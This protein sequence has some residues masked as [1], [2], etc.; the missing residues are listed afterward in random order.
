MGRSLHEATFAVVDVET[1]GIDPA[2]DRVVEVACV[3]TRGGRIIQTFSTLVHPERPIPASASAVHHITDT[4]VADAPRLANVAPSIAAMCADAIV[5]A[6]NA[7]FDLSFLP[8]LNHR[9]VLCSMRLAQRVV[10]DAPNHKNQVLRYHLGIDLSGLTDV[11]AHRALGDAEITSR[12]LAI[13]LERYLSQGGA[14][15]ASLLV[16]ELAAPR[17]L[18]ALPFG[19]HRGV[20][21]HEVPSDYL[22]WTMTKATSVSND[23]RFSITNELARRT[24]VN[25][26]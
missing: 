20:P 2:T 17:Q 7:S 15:D 9:P 23:A 24:T 6:H 10:P 26:Q 22:Q 12:I 11:I 1:T 19:R 8:F 4:M 25:L 18:D 5:V 14:D 13:C 21:L 3:L 16:S